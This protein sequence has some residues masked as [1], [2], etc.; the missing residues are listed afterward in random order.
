MRNALAAIFVAA[1]CLAPATPAYANPDPPQP[2][3]LVTDPLLLAVIGSTSDDVFS[4]TDLS[5]LLDPSTTPGTPT[6]HYGPYASGSPDSG[7]CG[8][9][10]A[11]DTFDRVFTVRPSATG[12]T[13][14]EQFK[15]GSFMT[16]AG[17]SPGGCETNVGGTIVAGVTGSMHGYFIISN[18]VGPQTSTSPNCDA[19]NETNHDCTTATFVNT[20]FAPCYPAECQVTTY[21]D[22]YAAGDQ[23]LALHEWKNASCDR[24][25]DDGDIAMTAGV[26]T[27]GICP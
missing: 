1:L 13:V 21:F 20:H 2:T 23:S 25:G 15:N 16:N 12:F 22:H 24:G 7:T 4:V 3:S 14:V 17:Q 9:E 26:L 11:I 18:V 8:N 27:K 19:A 6:Q 10:W 5:T